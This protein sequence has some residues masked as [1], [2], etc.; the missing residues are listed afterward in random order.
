MDYVKTVKNNMEAIFL[1]FFTFL[2]TLSGGIFSIKNQDRL[3][4][5]MSFTAGVLVAVC[6]F[7]ILPEVVSLSAEKHFP[8]INAFIAVVVGFL[9]FH[10]L[11]KT[12]I[13]HHS[14]EGEYTENQHHK[15]HFDHHHE[16]VG[17]VGALG[18]SFH[19]FLDGVGIG[20]GFHINPHV[21]LLI[22]IAVIA[23]DFSDGLNTVT[24]MLANK[25]TTR[26]AFLLLLLDATTPIL[27][28]LSTFLIH[29]PDNLLQLYLGFFAGFLL[30]IGA[31][32]LLPEAHSHHSS[33][34][35]LFLTIAGVLFIFLVTR[36]T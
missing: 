19:S 33:F 30:Y 11:E 17:L 25:N 9:A 8:I 23:H 2:S 12:I 18:L 29:I 1:S 27:G 15:H 34:K 35:M 7:D 3:H 5:I 10:I 14:H 20:L 31:S 26:R 4:Y 6:F 16:S 32:E 28:V 24:L 22:A 13:I 36:I 21:G